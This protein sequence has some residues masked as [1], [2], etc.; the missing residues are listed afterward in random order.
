MRIYMSLL[1]A[2]YCLLLASAALAIQ[3]PFG[4]TP[5][6]DSDNLVS[7]P[8]SGQ[9]PS[10]F[11][12]RQVFHHGTDEFP[13][14]H[15]RLD[16]PAEFHIA[17]AGD[18]ESTAFELSSVDRQATR[19][20]KRDCDSVESYL[21]KVR[22]REI[23]G[24][25]DFDWVHEIIPT[26][27]ITDRDTLVTLAKMTADA[28]VG[29]PDNA[30]WLDVGVP[31]NRS[32]DFGWDA[33]GIRG[34]VFA[35]EKNKTV[36]IAIKGTSAALFD[37]DG[38]TAPSDKINDNLLFSC[39]CSRVSYMWKTVC[40]CYDST[41][42]CK[43]D[44]VE[45]ALYE[46]DKYYRAVLDIYRNTTSIYP[47]A[48]IWLTGHSLGG[49]MASLL[50]RTYAAPTVTFEA[51]P[52]KLA[53]KRLHLP[54]PPIPEEETMIWHIG[55]TADPIYMGVCNGPSSICWMGGYAME[56]QCHSALECVYDTVN[57]K[58]WRV[59]STNHRIRNVV[60]MIASYN[61]TP[62]CVANTECQ[63]CFDWSYI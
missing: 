42:T 9:Y 50:G 26:P 13:K 58:N 17:S 20:A 40:D 62:T 38:E 63:D 1:V 27:N 15:R 41:Y 25:Q 5:T 30:N 34:H 53:A 46:E 19:M 56:T 10:G 14:L 4:L 55:N 33:A 7:S 3:L 51:P 48:T 11:T 6:T 21:E 44:C 29:L 52:E 59:S 43:Q 32:S 60:E 8:L 61:S 24:V 12:L 36:V 22:T 35:D 47:D 54:F 2:G 39:C 28:Y 23:V 31:Y 37:S 16:V 18:E 45:D 49:A 57:D